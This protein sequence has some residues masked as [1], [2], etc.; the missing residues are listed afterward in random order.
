MVAV[1][2]PDVV[3]HSDAGT[4]H[5]SVEVR[6]AEEVARRA[7]SFSEIGL[8]RRPALV[9]GVA[10]AVCMRDGQPFSVMAF[11][12]R[13]GKIVEVD[14]LRDVER[15]NDLDLTVLDG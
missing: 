5:A 8:V 14:I 2:D 6:G 10:G 1:L 3:L 11:T 15:L 4:S 13:A 7:R 12:V 9:N